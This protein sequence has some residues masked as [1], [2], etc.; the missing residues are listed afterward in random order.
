M[1]NLAYNKRTMI[2]LLTVTIFLSIY[3]TGCIGKNE[4]KSVTLI[5]L[6]GP[7]MMTSMEAGTIDA[8][9]A[10]E[11]WPALAFSEGVGEYLTNSSEIWSHHPCCVLAADWNWYEEIGQERVDEILN[12][13][14]LAHLR[15][16]E[17]I[18]KA[19]PKDSRNHSKLL[20]YAKELCGKDESV[21]E[22]AIKN[23]DFDY[24]FDHAA[25][26][27]YAERLM[28][29]GLFDPSKWEESGYV[30]T[31]EYIDS[32][33]DERYIDWAKEHK[34]DPNLSL[35]EEVSLRIGYLIAD[36]H[37]LALFVAK[38]EGFYSDYNINVTLHDPFVNGAAEM[39]DG[40]KQNTIQVGYLG[41]AP[42]MIQGINAN[43]F[44][45]NDAKVKLIASVNYNG[46][47]LMVRKGSNINGIKDLAGKKVGIPGP[48]TVQYFLALIACEKS[49]IKA[50]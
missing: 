40:F 5:K 49:G 44:N 19:L 42:A 17:W 39:Q 37:H 41:I 36:L 47:A 4:E 43:Y 16:T 46:S 18:A 6:N 3:F 8:I 24:N 21:I 33:V 12:Y 45:K 14:T 1:K 23:I 7:A 26:N 27:N 11:P 50:L 34:D 28:E 35:T 48:G 32:T 20:N 22:L 2:G 31:A 13:V 29:Y 38:E 10:W 9:I 15:A 30:S 25:I